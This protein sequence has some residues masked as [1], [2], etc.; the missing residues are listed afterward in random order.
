MVNVLKWT[1]VCR[2]VL[3][4]HLGPTTLIKKTIS[5]IRNSFL[6]TFLLSILFSFAQANVL[7]IPSNTNV[8]G[9]LRYVQAEGDESLD[10]IG[11]RFN[12]GYEE[13]VLANPNLERN[14]VLSP[15][16]KVVIPAQFIL[17][18]TPRRGIVI[19]LAEHR[20]YY[21]PP[22]ENVVVTFP[23]GIG[24]LG[25]ETP[26]GTTK[27]IS[28]ESNPTWRPTARLLAASEEKGVSLPQIF[29]P[30]LNNPLGKY[31]LRLGW[32]TILI[33]GTNQANRVGARV[34]AGCIRLLPDD[35]DYLYHT[36]AIGTAVRVINTP[37]KIGKYHGEFFMQVHFLGR[38][39]AHL[40]SVALQQLEALPIRSK[41]DKPLLLKELKHP[42]GLLF[43]LG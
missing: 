11:Q 39:P 2:L 37:V 8:V 30:G 25:W 40:Y 7:V 16:T 1:K 20:L 21:Y 32:P 6:I 4:G 3:L 31:V 13:M 33:H 14:D 35:I 15:Q 34:S 41:L 27:I 43:H 42:S 19:N 24:K 23:V 36:V 12:I 10:E 9:H 26:L 29:P 17:P 28:K 22:G 38:N 5:M 18:N